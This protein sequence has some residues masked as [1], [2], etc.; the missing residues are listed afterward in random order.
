MR[1]ADAI[2]LFIGQVPRTWEDKDLRP[3]FEPYGQIHELTVL[4]DRLTRNHKGN[5]QLLIHCITPLQCLIF[6][7]V[8]R[9]CISYF[10]FARSCLEGSEGVT[11]KE[12]FTRRKWFKVFV[13]ITPKK[14]IKRKHP[15]L[16]V[17]SNSRYLLKEILR[18]L[19]VGN[20]FLLNL[21]HMLLASVP[22][23]QC[24]RLYAVVAVKN[25]FF[26]CLE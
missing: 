10:L 20:E 21:Q 8:F 14:S 26:S 17:F 15:I 2:K 9:L 19:W 25:P 18:L 7:S 3:Y 1:D 4:R 13:V 6:F 24:F 22:C 23:L 5:I 12:N 16:H 11:R